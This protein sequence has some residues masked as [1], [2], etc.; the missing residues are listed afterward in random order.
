M[1]NSAIRAKTVTVTTAS[2]K[3]GRNDTVCG[4]IVCREATLKVKAPES[5]S[6]PRQVSGI[7]SAHMHRVHHPVLD[8][9]RNFSPSGFAIL[10]QRRPPM[11]SG[12]AAKNCH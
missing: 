6:R 1:P 3:G 12:V 9:L 5:Q 4:F 10:V 2:V 7:D 11:Y 8:N